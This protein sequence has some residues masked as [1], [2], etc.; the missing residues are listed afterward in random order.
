M[1][2]LDAGLLVYEECLHNYVYTHAVA[3]VNVTS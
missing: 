1:L 3:T 2:I